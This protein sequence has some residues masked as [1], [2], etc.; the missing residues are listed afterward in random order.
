MSTKTMAPVTG[1]TTPRI[2]TARSTSTRWAVQFRGCPFARGCDESRS[3]RRPRLLDPIE[4]E[5][6]RSPPDAFG[7]FGELRGFP[8]LPSRSVKTEDLACPAPSL[9]F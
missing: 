9:T 4:V 7:D 6:S 2:A 1:A 5:V 3:I 8:E